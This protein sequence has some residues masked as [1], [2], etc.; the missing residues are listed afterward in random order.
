MLR[1]PYKTSGLIFARIA[2]T[3]AE[4]ARCESPRDPAKNST[5]VNGR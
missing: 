4:T 2:R 1:H 3:F 5:A